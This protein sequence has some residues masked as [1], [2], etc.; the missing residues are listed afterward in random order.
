[1]SRFL[2]IVSLTLLILL[3]GGALFAQGTQAK[4]AWPAYAFSIVLGFGTGQYW[5]GA[6]GTPFLIGD[7]VGLA[8]IVI[9]EVVI[10]S[11]VASALASPSVSSV[12][13]AGT[14]VVVGY[15]IV[16]VGGLVYLVSRVWEF[17]D[18]FGAVDKA[19]KAGK[20]VEVVPVV[21]VRRTSFELGVSLKY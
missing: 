15:G 1:M 2:K 13:S 21:E 5:V 6:N 18:V 10:V 16:V 11:S 7:I 20:V 9:G 12:E 19:K 8:G 3:A 17:V 4:P 14:G